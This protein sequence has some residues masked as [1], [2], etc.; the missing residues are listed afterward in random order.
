MFFLACIGLCW[1]TNN[2][3]LKWKHYIEIY[4]INSKKKNFKKFSNC[5][6]IYGFIDIQ[7]GIW[8]YLR[9]GFPWPLANVWNLQ[10]RSGHVLQGRYRSPPLSKDDIY[11]G[12]LLY[13]NGSWCPY[14]DYLN[15]LNNYRLPCIISIKHVLYPFSTIHGNLAIG[16]HPIP[17]ISH[18]P[19]GPKYGTSRPLLNCAFFWGVFRRNIFW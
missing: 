16:Y 14:L 7:S 5:I 3:I 9:E 15:T 4:H 11:D 12:Y 2:N 6:K 13:H 1:R 10:G 17:I 8:G 19:G 18:T